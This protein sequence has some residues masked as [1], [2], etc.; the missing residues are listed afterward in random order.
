MPCVCCPHPPPLPVS[1]GRQ[2][3]VLRNPVLL[4]RPSSSPAWAPPPLGPS[5]P[6]PAPPPLSGA[7]LPAGRE[8][9]MLPEFFPAWHCFRAGG[10]AARTLPPFPRAGRPLADLMDPP[11]A[12]ARGCPWHCL[13][14]KLAQKW[15]C[16]LGTWFGCHGGAAREYHPPPLR[17]CSTLGAAVSAGLF[18]PPGGPLWRATSACRGP[19]AAASGRKGGGAGAVIRRP[20]Q[21]APSRSNPTDCSLPASLFRRLPRAKRHPC[22]C[23][24][25]TLERRHPPCTLIGP[26]PELDSLQSAPRP[27]APP[28][29]I[30][31]VRCGLRAVGAFL[32]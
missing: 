22:A 15:Y 21:R 20:R 18:E 3:L 4:M 7:P 5:R 32:C 25:H 12:V 14:P 13:V 24:P 19:G 8:F 9:W 28:I 2:G 29:R 17:S 30:P 6:G 1:G 16:F 31:G 27:R 11:G 23:S 26:K 10:G